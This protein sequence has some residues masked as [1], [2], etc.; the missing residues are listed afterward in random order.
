M[1]EFVRFTS[2]YRQSAKENRKKKRIVCKHTDTRRP[3]YSRK[4]FRFHSH[5]YTTTM[6]AAGESNSV[7]IYID[8]TQ[9]NMASG[10]GRHFFDE[11]QMNIECV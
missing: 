9:H 11:M 7:H 8:R 6:F 4:H 3:L 2:P 5:E 10:W 1:N